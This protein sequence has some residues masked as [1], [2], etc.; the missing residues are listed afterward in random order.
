MI[1]PSF[2]FGAMFVAYGLT[3]TLSIAIFVISNLFLNLNLLQTFAAIIVVLLLS[4][5]INLR[6]SRIIWINIF[7]SYSKEK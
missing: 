4:A 7:V 2:F 1:E 5:P 6:I 3:V